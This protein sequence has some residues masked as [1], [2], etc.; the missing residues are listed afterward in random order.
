MAT[1]SKYTEKYE[2]LEIPMN[3]ML[4]PKTDEDW[5]GRSATIP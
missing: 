3:E 5:H 1:T 2:A 4:F